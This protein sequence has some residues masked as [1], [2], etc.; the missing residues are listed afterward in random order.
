MSQADLVQ[1]AGLSLITAGLSPLL[2]ESSTAAEVV[3]EEQ[4]EKFYP[5]PV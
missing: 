1:F 4:H 3:T 5:G 2:A